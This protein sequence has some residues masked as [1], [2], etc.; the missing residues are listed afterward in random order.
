ML[1]IVC[2]DSSLFQKM[3]SCGLFIIISFFLITIPLTLLSALIIS[4]L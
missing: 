3:L 2:E 1:S 4:L